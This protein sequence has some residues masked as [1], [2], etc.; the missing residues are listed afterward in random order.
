MK[1]ELVIEGARRDV[2]SGNFAV[3]NPAWKLNG[4]LVFHGHSRRHAAHRGLRGGRGRADA[5][6]SAR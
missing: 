6:P 5:A 2:H 3:P 4:L 1:I